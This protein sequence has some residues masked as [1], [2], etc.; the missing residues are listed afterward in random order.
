MSEASPALTGAD[1]AMRFGACA[2][3]GRPLTEEEQHYYGTAC[4]RC[5]SEMHFAM[6]DDRDPVL[7]PA[8][9]EEERLRAENATLRAR[10]T[11]AE[12]LRED[13]TRARNAARYWEWIH[14]EKDKR[15]AAAQARATAAEATLR[16][17]EA[18]IERLRGS[19]RDISAQR[20]VLDCGVIA[21][22]ALAQP[23][24]PASHDEA[25]D[26]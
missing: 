2:H 21:R 20:H 18:E 13:L 15:L 19:L 10:A 9:N 16:E 26:V 24:T 14:G 4:D 25:T 23:T 17:R 8:E 12:E 7:P 5:E 11:A 3:C 1:Q 6:Q 22:A